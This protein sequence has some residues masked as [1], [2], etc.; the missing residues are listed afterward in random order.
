MNLTNLR[1]TI[2]IGMLALTLAGAA[3]AVAEDKGAA[4]L[5]LDSLTCGGKAV[6]LLLQAGAIYEGTAGDDVA[7]G[8]PN[9]DIFHGNGGNDTACLGGDDIATGGP[10]ADRLD[11]GEGDDDLFGGR[12]HE[13]DGRR[14]P[15]IL[16][17]GAACRSGRPETYRSGVCGRVDGRDCTCRVA[18]CPLTSCD[19]TADCCDG[20]CFGLATSAAA[21][22]GSG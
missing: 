4:L 9:V 19:T 10:G 21:C 22:V 11:G 18:A 14:R 1:T 12:G 8:G 16:G 17:V 13:R 3:A 2:G 7:L 20:R 5:A 15:G 6:T